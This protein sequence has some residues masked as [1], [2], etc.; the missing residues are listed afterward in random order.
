MAIKHERVG[1]KRKANNGMWMTIIAYRNNKDIDVEFEDGSII[2]HKS[3]QSFKNGEIARFSNYNRSGEQNIS[4]QGFKM[5]IAR[6]GSSK[7]ID[8]QFEDGFT[9]YNR[10]YRDFKM[11]T[12]SHPAKN[13]RTKFSR[14]GETNTNNLGYK[15]TIIAYR[16]TS[17]IDIQFEDGTTVHNR[18]YYDFLKG[19]IR[20]PGK[21]KNKILTERIGETSI[22][23]CGMMM[24]IIGYKKSSDIDIMFEDGTIV[25]HKEY[26]DFLN[27]AIRHPDIYK[28]G[29]LSIP[30]AIL[31]YYLKQIGFEK[32]K[33]GYF[34]KFHKDFKRQ[35]L[36]LFNESLMIGIEY[37]GFYFHKGNT[38][39]NRDN[40]K[41]NLSILSSIKLFRIREKG[42]KRTKSRKVENIMLKTRKYDELISFINILLIYIKEKYTIEYFIDMNLERDYEDIM[43]FHAENSMISNRTKHIGETNVAKNGMKMTII[44]FRGSNDIDV[45]FEDGTVVKKQTYFNFNRGKIGSLLYRVKNRVGETM[46][47]SNGMKMTIIAYRGAKD[48]DVQFEDG[49]IVTEKTYSCF[50][51]GHI[52]VIPRAELS[53]HRIGETKTASN[54]MK[55]TIIAYRGAKD[56]DVQ[57]EDGTIVT[58]KTYSSFK[59]GEIAKISLEQYKKDKIGEK[60]IAKNGV[61][62]KIIEWRNNNDIDIQFKDGTIVQHKSYKNFKDGNIKHPHIIVKKQIKNREGETNMSRTGEKMTIIAYRNARDI[63]V[64]FEDGIIVYNKQYNDFKNGCISKIRKTDYKTLR[65]GER[66]RATNGMLMEIIEYYKHDN[67][68]IR[69]EDGTVVRN[70]AYKCFQNGQVA[71]PLLNKSQI[72]VGEESVAQNGMKMK[73]ITYRGSLDMDVQFED[74]F[75]AYHVRYEHFKKGSIRNP[76]ISAYGRIKKPIKTE[77]ILRPES[78]AS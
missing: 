8:I 30:E 7:D 6:Y 14:V 52:R 77:Q 3:Y 34:C 21:S 29:Y 58:G 67:I 18:S 71:H 25:K 39:Y 27:G 33:A 55:M 28:Y 51:R 50:R 11:G 17:D 65:V 45:Q 40:K 32:K 15:M 61:L 68:T 31:L 42:L 48:I 63:D 59:E 41:D 74:G 64:Q 47:A 2:S 73:I 56:I 4:K 44:D 13:P 78:I 26:D 1:E 69:F 16:K 38:Q 53:Q 43:R 72:R 36:D 66:N 24:T 60:N 12:V 20:H 37:D 23:T 5:T 49:T 46:T 70:K 22:A 10:C 76:N 57:F 62:M 54:G 9:V 75:I 35:E 19:S